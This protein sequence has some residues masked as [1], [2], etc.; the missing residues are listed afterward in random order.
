MW[1]KGPKVGAKSVGKVLGISIDISLCNPASGTDFLDITIT[2]TK[3]QEKVGLLKN[4][5]LL[6]FKQHHKESKGANHK[7]QENIPIRYL[8]KR[9]ESKRGK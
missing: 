7:M 3:A 6:C 5:E 1:I 8:R 4:Y 2:T 9:L